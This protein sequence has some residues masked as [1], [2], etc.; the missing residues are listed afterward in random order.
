[1]ELLEIHP[2]PFTWILTPILIKIF[3][4]RTD[5]ETERAMVFWNMVLLN[6]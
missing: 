6:I 5:G 2:K 1:M 4:V 3:A